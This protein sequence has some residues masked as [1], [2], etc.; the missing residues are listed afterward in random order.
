MRWCGR[1]ASCWRACRRR[2]SFRISSTI[3]LVLSDPG[4]GLAII[5]TKGSH[6]PANY[7]LPLTI[8]WTRLDRGRYNPNALAAVRRGSREGTLLDA[9]ADPN[10]IAFL[11]ENLRASATIETDQGRI[12]FKPTSGLPKDGQT[13]TN[14][15]RAVDTEQS[16]KIGRA[17]V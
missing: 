8:S 15:V 14:D 10:F 9:T 17:H 6:A 16:N 4:L 1:W 12:E 11:L 13:A 7:L 3:P 2:P 5:E